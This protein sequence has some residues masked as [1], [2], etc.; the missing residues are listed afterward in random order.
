MANRLLEIRRKIDALDRRAGALLARRLA[1][2]VPLKRLKK[3]LTDPAREK[4]VLANA[5]AA[6]GAGSPALRRALRAIYAE[7]IRQT[8]KLQDADKK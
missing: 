6:A 5:A 4:R 1:L 8:K 2:A 3:N 7:V